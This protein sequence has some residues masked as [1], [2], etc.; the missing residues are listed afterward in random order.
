MLGI[1]LGPA[2]QLAV[3][4]SLHYPIR[5]THEAW[6]GHLSHPPSYPRSWLNRLANEKLKQN[7]GQTQGQG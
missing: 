7:L 3:E 5:L 6:P 1:G 4:S 2:V